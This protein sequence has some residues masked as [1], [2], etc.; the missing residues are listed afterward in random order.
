M[1]SK[2]LIKLLESSNKDEE[3]KGLKALIA[4]LATKMIRE[5]QKFGD[6]FSLADHGSI[7]EAERNSFTLN[8]DGECGLNIKQIEPN[9]KPI[10]FNIVE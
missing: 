7:V 4:V 3:N 2:K 9:K 10:L 8:M 5:N 6:N 1:N